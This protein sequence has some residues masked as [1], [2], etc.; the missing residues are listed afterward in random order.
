[1]FSQGE[2]TP[3]SQSTPCPARHLPA[4]PHLTHHWLPALATNA[5][6]ECTAPQALHLTFI[7]SSPYMKKPPEGG[8]YR[9]TSWVKV[10]Y[11]VG[12]I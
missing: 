10:L 7:F 2:T 11:V 9:L 8:F 3:N 1:M 4:T 6:N 12:Q 5:S